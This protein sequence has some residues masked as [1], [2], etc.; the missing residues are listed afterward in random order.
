MHTLVEQNAIT[1][2]RPRM[3]EMF[4]GKPTSLAF[5]NPHGLH[6]LT[7]WVTSP[8]HGTKNHYLLSYFEHGKENKYF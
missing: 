2:S 7:K 4:V 8:E 3:N 5:A 1:A 6:L